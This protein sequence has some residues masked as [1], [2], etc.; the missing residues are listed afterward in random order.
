[1]AEPESILVVGAGQAGASLVQTLRAE[2]YGGP[3]TL[4]GAEP[5][6][7]YQRP[8][9]SKK[10]LLGDFA[11]ERLYL[12]PLSYYDEAEIRL[13]TDQAAVA[14]DAA[15]REVR[16]ANGS[17]LGYGALALTTG[18]IA[19]RLPGAA[20]GDLAGVHVVRTRADVDGLAPEVA[21]GRRALVVGGGY[22]GLEAAAVLA[23]RGL[24]VTL[25]ER[26]ERILNRVA[27]A[28]TAAFL[29]ALHQSH[30]VTIREGAL[31][32]RLEGEGR[33]AAVVF[34]DG[35]RLEIDLAIVGIGIAP[36]TG[37]AESAGLRV[38]NGIAVDA[39]CR[40]SD[41]AIYA[42]GDCASFPWEDGRIRLESVQN[43]IDQGAHAARAM[44]GAEAPYRPYPWFWSD[45][46]DAKLQIAGLSTD[47]TRVIE[48]PGS[49]PSGRS[50]WYF[51]GAAFVAIDAVSDP[52]AYMTGKRWLEAGQHPDPE[53][54]A[55]PDQDLRGLV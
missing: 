19:R 44:L 18:A 29:R 20:G 49:R 8:P 1:M 24:R 15:A 35:E 5:E 46:Y 53:A 12:K 33:V 4:V 40:T 38:E 9:L 32:A 51:R 11:A 42:A 3:V 54:L 48:R 26:A 10:Y 37:L 27:S 34:E 21:P 25:V 30:G 16:L 52:K 50:F 14:V 2:G 55:N 23:S 47:H 31:M 17:T 41:A 36:D 7:P 13:I 22:I 43:A 39:Q 45:Q 28:E 6:P